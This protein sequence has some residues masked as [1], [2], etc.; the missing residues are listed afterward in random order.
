MKYS[1]ISRLFNIA[2]KKMIADG[3]A[4]G[5]SPRPGRVDGAVVVMGGAIS[6]IDKGTGYSP[7]GDADAGL[8]MAV[9][10]GHFFDF[11]E[12]RCASCSGE[13]SRTLPA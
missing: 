13:G 1:D 12:I 10:R 6:R 4:G 2:V 8:E 11:G 3:G 9:D 5:F 7:T